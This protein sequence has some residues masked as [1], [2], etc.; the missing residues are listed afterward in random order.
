MECLRKADSKGYGQTQ[1]DDYL[2][3]FHFAW[4]P[5]PSPLFEFDQNGSKT[6]QGNDLF[7]KQV[8]ISNFDL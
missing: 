1:A 4:F 8:E 5:S 6:N 7:H 3:G 2:K